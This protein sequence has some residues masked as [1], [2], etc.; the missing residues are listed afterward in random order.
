MYPNLGLENAR[1]HTVR[2]DDISFMATH[3]LKICNEA[4]SQFKYPALFVDDGSQKLDHTWVMF[5]DKVFLDPNKIVA[6]ETTHPE[7]A[8]YLHGTVNL[9]FNRKNLQMFYDQLQSIKE[10]AGMDNQFIVIHAKFSNEIV[11]IMPLPEFS[12]RFGVNY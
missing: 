11:A 6:D 9:K 3:W 7:L 1:P 12:E 8:G 2:K 4:E 10:K 5:R